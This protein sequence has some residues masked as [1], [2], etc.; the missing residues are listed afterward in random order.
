[1]GVY[2]SRG[3]VSNAL[4]G[5][6][7]LQ[8]WDDS[9][10]RTSG[11]PFIWS[12]SP[13]T[14]PPAPTAGLGV[15]WLPGVTLGCSPMWPVLIGPSIFAGMI[16]KL[17]QELATLRL[18]TAPLPSLPPLPLSTSFLK[19]QTHLAHTIHSSALKKASEESL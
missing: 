3:Q 18:E 5:G 14:P 13:F 19:T 9:C 6:W 4:L 1:M 7:G 10:R 8:S 11:W 15:R 16:M 2:G 12:P 17:N